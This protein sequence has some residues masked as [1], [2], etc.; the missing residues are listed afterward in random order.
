[1]MEEVD[2]VLQWTV[3]SVVGVRSCFDPRTYLVYLGGSQHVPTKSP[4][5]LWVYLYSLAFHL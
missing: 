5:V 3:G 4:Q 1:M 2:D